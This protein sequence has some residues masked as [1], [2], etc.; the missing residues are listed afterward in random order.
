[1]HEEILDRVESY[2][3]GRFAEHGTTA[4][5]VDWN[6]TESQQTRFAQLLRVCE[7][8]DDFS[9]NDYGCGYGALADYLREDGRRISYRGY[10]LSSEMLE[11]ARERLAGPDTAFVGDVAELQPADYTVASG[12]FNVKLETE[13]SEWTRYA[14]DT[15]AEL[16][17]L[18]GKGLAFNMLT[19]YSDPERM[20]PDLFYGEPGFFFDHC[21]T[22]ISRELALLQDYGLFEFTLLVRKTGRR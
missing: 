3:S 6:S 12:I 16:D 5:G 18:S 22:T 14:L 2:Y 17:R 8:D 21:A 1:M 13:A 20:R 7:G 15:I 10:D 19:S 4:R 9:L 11:A